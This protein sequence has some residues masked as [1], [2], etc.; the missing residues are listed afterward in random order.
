V[1]AVVVDMEEWQSVT[2]TGG[3]A[4]R[5]FYLPDDPDI[6]RLVEGLD[7]NGMLTLVDAREG[8]SIHS[9]SFVGSVNIGP[10][11]IRVRP[12]L[13]PGRFASL[14]GYGL[15]LH[16]L[17]LFSEHRVSVVAPAF[18][19][20]LVQQLCG[21]ATRII[22]RGLSLHCGSRERPLGAPRGG[23]RV[24]NLSLMAERH[25]GILMNTVAR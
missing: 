12:K 23:G 15:H 11:T 6:R 21:E 25:D 3:A 7:R 14:V 9:T 24:V 1:S 19:D 20:L 4:L 18:Q 17:T 8:L 2:P 16:S 13:D 10:V 22:G 5:N